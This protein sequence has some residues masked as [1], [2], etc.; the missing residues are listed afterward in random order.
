MS[1][2]DNEF[3]YGVWYLISFL[4]AS[5]LF[6]S[7]SRVFLGEN[8][9]W[10]VKMQLRTVLDVNVVDVQ[11]RRNPSKHYV[12]CCLLV[13]RF[14][15]H[16]VQV[17]VNFISGGS[18]LHTIAA[19]YFCLYLLCGWQC[20][21]CRSVLLFYSD[22]ILWFSSSATEVHCGFKWSVSIMDIC[23]TNDSHQPQL[24]FVFCLR[25]QIW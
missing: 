20:W 15:Y 13:L 11:K 8:P 6:C 5:I 18:T 4:W 10:C 24:Y 3:R 2:Q 7:F 25:W 19:D 1:S 14:C 22:L 23:I 17:A 9:I 12:S 16:V 21:S